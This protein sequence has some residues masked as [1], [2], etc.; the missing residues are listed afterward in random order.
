MLDSKLVTKTCQQALERKHRLKT[1]KYLTIEEELHLSPDWPPVSQ[2]TQSLA[3]LMQLE[4]TPVHQTPPGGGT[5]SP[6]FESDDDDSCSHISGS[7]IRS[8]SQNSAVSQNS[9][10][11]K[12][13]QKRSVGGVSSPDHWTAV[14][15][16]D[17]A[18][19]LGSVPASPLSP[20]LPLL[21]SQFTTPPIEGSTGSPSVIFDKNDPFSQ[22]SF[23]FRVL[24]TET[25]L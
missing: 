21:E 17:D 18:P 1:Q 5:V 13:P 11:V 22:D 4:S 10:T 19:I 2:S 15:V 20:S 23:D 25:K 8:I 24:P 3:E 12:S 16:S 9:V 14:A 7:R 6:V